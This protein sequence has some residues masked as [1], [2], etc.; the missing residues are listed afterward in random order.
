MRAPL[1]ARNESAGNQN[2]ATKHWKQQVVNLT[3]LS[4]LVAP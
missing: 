3:T 2:K 1:A 4:L